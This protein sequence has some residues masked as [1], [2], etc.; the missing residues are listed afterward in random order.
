M[1]FVSIFTTLVLMA[2]LASLSFSVTAQEKMKKRERDE[3]KTKPLPNDPEL[4][5][6]HRDFVKS[7]E[8]LAVKY[9]KEK[10]WSKAKDCYEEI[11]KLVPAY[12][13]A[14]AKVG[15]LLQMEATA[16]SVEPAS[17]SVS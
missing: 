5:A 6:L 3:P 2:L 13:P 4:L 1:R 7:A 8:K 16:K 14:R 11:L 10:E 17:T 15:D 9:E 12:P